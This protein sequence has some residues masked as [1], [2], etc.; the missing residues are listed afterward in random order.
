MVIPA[1]KSLYFDQTL[2]SLSRQTCKDFIVYIGDD[3]SPENLIEIIDK[4]KSRIPIVYKRFESNLGGLDLV[5]HWERCIDLVKEEEW[6]WFFSDDDVASSDC[7]EGFYKTLKLYDNTG[8]LFNKVLRFNLVITDKELNPAHKYLTP[9]SFSVEYFL[10]NQFISHTLDNRA[11]EFIFYRSSFYEKGKFVKFP[12]AWGSDKATILKLAQPEGFITI[13]KGEVFWRSSEHNISGNSNQLM[14]I[15][16]ALA[17]N[18]RNRWMFGFIQSYRSSSFFYGMVYRIMHNITTNQ[19]FSILRDRGIKDFRLK[20][21]VFLLGGF[22][23][24]KK[25][26]KFRQIKQV[27]SKIFN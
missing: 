7:V 19:A 25:I 20:F 17:L 18:Q 2:D 26:I 11:V 6:I 15:P 23:R 12:L 4:Y 5:A 3:A 1:Y 10:E 13:L 8:N 24:F 22:I 27:I 9:D 21:I 16:K 14:N